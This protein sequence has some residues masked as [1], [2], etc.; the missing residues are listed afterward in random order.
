MITLITEKPSV[1]KDIAKII[2]AT[3]KC[4]GYFTGNGYA[5]TWAFG[6][7]VQLAMPSNYGYPN[8]KKECLPILPEEFILIPRQIKAGKE[9]KNDP[10]AYKQLQIIQELFSK[11]E[12][13]IVATDAGREGELIFR[14]IYH[15]L[16]CSKPFE[17][18]WISSLTDKAIKKGL[19]NLK[20]GSN[21]DNL[22]QAAKRRAEA[23]WLIGINASQSLSIA[24]KGIYSLGRVQTPTLSMICKR[25][26]EHINFKAELYWQIAI[27]T[28]KDNIN[29]KALCPERFLSANKATEIAEKVKNSGS[30]I[31]KKV[32][33]KE[34]HENPPLLF[35]LTALQKEANVKLDYTADKT[36]S[37]AQALYEKKVLSYPRTGSCYISEDVFE[38]I[39]ALI[40]LIAQY[41]KFK[42]YAQQLSG[43]ELNRHSVNNS[44]VTDHHAL[45]I[46]ENK[47]SGL[48]VEEQALY[49]MVAVRILEAFSEKCLKESTTIMSDASGI[50]FITKG[51]VIKKAGWREILPEKKEEE[52][53]SNSP[54]PII[55]END[56]LVIED[57]ENIEKQ[58][59]PKQLHTEATLLSAMENCG[60]QLDNKELKEAM[61]EVGI[62][63]PAT[64][65]SIIET[66]FKRDYIKREKNSRSLIPTEKGMSVYNA[67]KEKKISDIEMTGQWENTLAKIESGEMNPN[68]F[69]KSIEVY[70]EQITRELLDIKIHTFISNKKSHKCPKCGGEFSIYDKV[71][72]CMNENC[73]FII[74]RL[75]AGKTM[76]EEHVETLIAKGY[77]KP[78]KGFISKTGKKFSAILK[79]DK[80]TWQVIFEF[81]DK[82]Q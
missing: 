26:Q 40:N 17:R 9:Y 39:P 46:T 4:D 82:K 22:Y 80:N 23:D 10:G 34:I 68:T 37:I 77:T 78:I 7:L 50:I 53:I 72:K 45:L 48:T 5:V 38:E 69:H 36:L 25:Y 43:K 21:Y 66:L 73:G 67:I 44:K 6:H 19:S 74:F 79:L 81:N 27:Q 57:V 49:D 70:A 76:T 28:N 65:A 64:R 18:L 20:P 24:G 52:E 35:D 13:I 59:Q 63:T 33:K 55:E 54:L 3:K 41:D 29:F 71:G 2:S 16:K 30:I 47:A 1:A 75:K 32:E 56:M 58:T 51:I 60:K 42:A 8:F 62:G 31:V 14:Y 11:S 61:K 15:F 12:K